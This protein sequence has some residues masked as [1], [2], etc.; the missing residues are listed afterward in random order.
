MDGVSWIE[1]NVG[2]K[3]YLYDITYN[4]KVYVIVGEAGIILTSSDTLKWTKQKSNYRGGFGAGA[5]NSI[6]WTGK[7]F[8]AVSI[9]ENSLYSVDGVN[10]EF[11]M[12]S[13]MGTLDEVIWKNNKLTAVGEYGIIFESKDG[14]NWSKVI[15][16]KRTFMQDLIYT[17]KQFVAVGGGI[18]LTSPDGSKWTKVSINTNSTWLLSCLAWDSKQYIAVD[19]GGAVMG[20]VDAKKWS[21]KGCINQNNIRSIVSSGKR[22]VAIGGTDHRNRTSYKVAV[23][24]DGVKWTLK[25]TADKGLSYYGIIWYKNMFIIIGEK[26]LIMTSQ[27]GDKWTLRYANTTKDFDS[28]TVV[29]NKLVIVDEDNYKYSSTDGVIWKKE[30]RMNYRGR[31]TN[32]LYNGKYYAAITGKYSDKI[33]LSDDGINWTEVQTE[34]TIASL[35]CNKDRFVAIGD[36]SILLELWVK[37]HK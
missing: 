21:Y 34:M 31:L 3:E 30:E 2:S 8:V 23:S 26:G 28:I 7:A 11:V 9:L 20:S 24:A 4:G 29:E 22:F 25:D 35:A 33:V 14:K 19:L 1:I 12:G 5:I 13:G 37:G 36:G 10:W 17:G 27:N 15:E 32:M 18:I 6:V 16:G